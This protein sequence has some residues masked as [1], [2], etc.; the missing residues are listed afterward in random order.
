MNVKLRYIS[1]LLL[2]FTFAGCQREEL[3]EPDRPGMI[4]ENGNVTVHFSTR[5]PDMAEIVTRAVDPDGYGVRSL[6]LFCFD[7]YRHYIGRVQATNIQQGTG[8]GNGN[9]GDD[10]LSGSF[11]AS[12]PGSAR[13]IHF[14]ANLNVNDFDDT[15]NLGRLDTEVIPEFTTTSGLLSYWGYMKFGSQT[16]LENFAAGN[17]ETVQLFRNQARFQHERIDG[18]EN[19]SIKG[20]ALVNE[21]SRGTVAPYDRNADLA[22]G[23]DPFGFADASSITEPTL[24]AE[25][26]KLV[27]SMPADVV[28]YSEGGDARFTFEHE[29]TASNPLFLIFRIN[30]SGGANADTEWSDSD[31]YYKIALIDDEGN[32]LSI[33][34]NYLYTI[35]FNGIPEEMGYAT[36]DEAVNG[37]ASNNV[38]VSIDQTISSVGDGRSELAVIGET[39]R[40]IT[41]ETLNPDG[42]YTIRYTWFDGSGNTI[43]ITP[44]VSWTEGGN[45]GIA[46]NNIGNDFI[47]GTSKDNPGTGTIT[48][49]PLNI[50]APQYGTLQIKAGKFVRTVNLISLTNF[51]FSPVWTSS[52]V[53]MKTGEQVS[54]AFTVPDN[55]PEEL[56]PL[57]VKISANLFDDD[58]SNVDMDGNQTYLDVIFEE[59]EYI[60]D[61]NALESGE[62]NPIQRDWSY[63]YVYTVDRPGLHRVNFETV[64]N[65]YHPNEGEDPRIEFFIEA[66]AFTT[67]RQYIYMTPA[68]TDNDYRIM[69]GY[70]DGTTD[71]SIS[72]ETDANSNSAQ[73]YVPPIAGQEFHLH[74]KFAEGGDPVDPIQGEKLRI[75]VDDTKMK[76]VNVGED[77]LPCTT[78]NPERGYYYTYTV[79][80][81]LRNTY[82]DYGV[83]IPMRT[84]SSDC[85]T[86]I[87]IA[88]ENV[89]SG[90]EN[91]QRTYRSA[92]LTTVNSTNGSSSGADTYT[93]TA[94]LK[95]NNQSG[96]S[97]D[98]PYGPGEQVDL[99]VG[100]P[101]EMFNYTKSVTCFIATEHLSPASGE[102]QLTPIDGGYIFTATSTE[103]VISMQTNT[104]ASAETVTLSEYDGKVAFTPVEL[105]IGNTEISGT[106]SFANDVNGEFLLE[107]P[108]MSLE[109]S[110]G[111]RLGVFNVKRDASNPREGTFTLSLRTEYPLDMDEQ[112]YVRFSPYPIANTEFY[113]DAV[114]LRSLQDKTQVVLEKGS[115]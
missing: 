45:T 44:E 109:R 9:V 38:W 80:D 90:A 107:N 88:S 108:Y 15:P 29:N 63:K 40:I 91:G 87:R 31:R 4:D 20:Y 112:I 67:V 33:L 101:S 11:E 113:Q 58:G 77:L 21:Y 37:A 76:P 60:L 22:Q 53:P 56:Y 54:I 103:T 94:A 46:E 95:Y 89:A 99:E 86:Y 114:T 75:Y 65:D 28:R 35:R 57:D 26:D 8:G 106:V 115:L 100:I 105:T 102:V 93:F 79:P 59:C 17:G 27:A 10:G 66:E 82:V 18:G 50:G 72:W 51:S 110:D 83:N 84:L 69:L 71:D 39:T 70:H 30:T 81:N 97:I 14:I 1:L 32:Q 24:C 78:P 92:I 85:E 43:K 36:F 104:V 73:V 47:P 49:S 68:T 3:V 42:T 7:S 13:Y 23:G 98:L 62:N 55:F 19:L 2:L 96:D 64:L 6:W 74:F 61:E 48:I 5:I 16:E 34:R 52:G 41:P 12:V 111:T 25:E